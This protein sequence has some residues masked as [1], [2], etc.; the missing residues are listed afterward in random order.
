MRIRAR[1]AAA[2]AAFL[3]RPTTVIVMSA[4]FV[5]DIARRRQDE[6]ERIVR[7]A[8]GEEGS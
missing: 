2:W 3:G 5:N 8:F 6:A 4:P 7:K 1:L